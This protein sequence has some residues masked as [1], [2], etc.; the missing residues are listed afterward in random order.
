M[1]QRI[2]LSILIGRKHILFR[3]QRATYVYM[4]QMKSII[5]NGYVVFILGVWCNSSEYK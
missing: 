2:T 4:I 5:G 3:N 1:L